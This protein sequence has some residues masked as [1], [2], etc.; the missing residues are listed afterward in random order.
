MTAATDATT[1]E[2]SSARVHV[3]DD[4]LEREQHRGDRR[5]ERRGQRAGG[6][7]RHEIAHALAATDAATGRSTD[8]RP[9]PICTDGPFAAHRMA[10]AD[11]QHA[12]E[13]LA[14][15]HARRE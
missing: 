4:L 3:A 7:D 1:V 12:G 2:P 10:G 13:E 15:R 9:A 5:V 8:A 14:E 11:A 6:A